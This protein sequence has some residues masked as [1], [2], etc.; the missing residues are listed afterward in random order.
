MLLSC[1]DWLSLQIPPYSCVQLM[2]HIFMSHAKK[3]SVGHLPA[4]GGRTGPAAEHLENAQAPSPCLA[5]L[6]TLGT[7]HMS[8]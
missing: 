4:W 2:A 7:A 3:Y 6:P 5:C 8:G 1:P